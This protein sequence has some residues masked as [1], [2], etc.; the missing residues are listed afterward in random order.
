MV[1]CYRLYRL[2]LIRDAILKMYQEKNRRIQA[3]LHHFFQEKRKIKLVLILLLK[4][5]SNLKNFK[6]SYWEKIFSFPNYV[7]LKIGFSRKNAILHIFTRK[8]V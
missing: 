6:E 7:Y 4:N 8:K 3:F 5:N 1:C 2:F